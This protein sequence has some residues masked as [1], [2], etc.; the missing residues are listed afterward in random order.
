M[1]D[2]TGAGLRGSRFERVDL[3]GSK[4]RITDLAG[5]RFRDVGLTGCVMRGVH[6]D[7]GEMRPADP[8]GF[9]EAWDILCAATGCRP[10]S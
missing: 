5:S 4:F 1:A 3:T 10:T 8:A 9:R 6:P 2:F 7:P